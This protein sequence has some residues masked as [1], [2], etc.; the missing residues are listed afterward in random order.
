MTRTILIA[1]TCFLLAMGGQQ[2]GAQAVFAS[3]A[4]SP[5]PTATADISIL[6]F[7]ASATKDR[8]ILYWTLDKN[9]AVDQI[10]VERSMDEKIFVVTGLVFGTDQ[11]EKA[12][13]LFYEKNKNAKCY[14]RLK[15][16]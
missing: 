14:Y 4:A 12:E 3:H 7:N 16:I 15:I 11:P 1:F 10:L 5:G 2:A 8:V 13:Y 9:Q 6:N